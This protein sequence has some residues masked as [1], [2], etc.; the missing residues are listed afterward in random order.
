M[1][2]LGFVGLGTMGG[3]M[4]ARLL[5]KGHTVTGY[6]RT[7]SKAQWLIDRGMKWADSPQAAAAASDVI[8]TMVTNAAA[9]AAI[10]DG[11][12]GLLA[13]RSAG[14]FLIDMQRLET[15]IPLA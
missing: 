15:R 5:E 10:H 6:N 11:T 14:K 7:K 8:F 13:G 2:N 12:D 3:N 9:L 4:V 1:S